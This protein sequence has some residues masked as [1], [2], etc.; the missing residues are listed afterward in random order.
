MEKQMRA[1]INDQIMTL[2]KKGRFRE[3]G[4]VNAPFIKDFGFTTPDFS[5]RTV[6]AD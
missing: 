4:S 3:I 2:L 6:K 1:I 5:V